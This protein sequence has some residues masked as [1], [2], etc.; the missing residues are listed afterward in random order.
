MTFKRW[1][2]ETGLCRES[3]DVPAF[4]G[5]TAGAFSPDGET[6]VVARRD[7]TVEL[8]GARSGG[9]FGSFPDLVVSKVSVPRGHEDEVTACAFAPNGQRIVSASR[10]GTLRLWGVLSMRSSRATLRGHDGWVN[11]CAFSPKGGSLIV[12]GG[13]DGTLRLWRADSGALCGILE[14]HTDA[15][16]ACAFAPNEQRIVSA[17]RD[18]TIKLWRARGGAEI[19]S[20]PAPG[21]LLACAFSPLGDRFCCGGARGAVYV[22]E[23]AGGLAAARAAVRRRGTGGPATRGRSGAAS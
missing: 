3:H 11:A 20:F 21:G 14:G 13:E 1:D 18:G 15:V 10:D 7:N 22:F 19:L 4:R 6:I 9:G 12:S 16:T 2:V 17:S 8:R 23:L 5:V